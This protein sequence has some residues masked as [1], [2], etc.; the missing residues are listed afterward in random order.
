M[1]RTKNIFSTLKGDRA[2]WA[3]TAFLALFS[4]LPVFS[5]SSNLAYLYGNGETLPFLVRHFMHLVLGFAIIYGVHKVPAHYF[6]GLSIIGVPIVIILLLITMAQGTTIDGANASRWIK[7]PFVGITFQTSTLASVVLMIY[8]ARYLSKIKDQQIT[9]KE[10]ILPLW[11]PVALILGLILPANFSTTAIIFAM[12]LT[13]VFM[14]GY[15]FKYLAIIV[16]TG[17][18]ALTMFILAAKAFPG[19]FPN[20]VDTWMSRIDSFADDEDSE[21]DY[22][23]EKAKIAIATGG[24]TG[25][26][27]G[28]S[29]QKNFLPQSSS[30]FIYAII[31]EEFGLVGGLMLLLMYLL[32][33]FRIL[34]VAHKA[35]TVF[36]K[37]AVM[38]V[39][40][41]IVFQALINMAVAVE[42]FPV[43]GQTLPLVSS[44]GTSIWMTC[45][46]I[47]I[48][49]SVSAKREEVRVKEEE[50][51]NP[52][53][54]L[55][56]AM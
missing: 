35:D 7:V 15:P 52:L 25:L 42:L 26:G 54:V 53:D 51:M 49:L 13:L 8:I 16:A 47:G 18:L 1:S 27:P 33:L 23:I 39:G 37:L 24:L 34:V 45:L 9:F 55:S 5:A 44:G 38:G 4:F 2:I 43:T 11:V 56:E 21:G 40:L 31:V 48:I 3:I 36:G 29:V 12:V 19:V 30:D 14:G 6:K 20:R 46:A 50:E 32:L 41:P 10:S 22:Q 17:L 28:K